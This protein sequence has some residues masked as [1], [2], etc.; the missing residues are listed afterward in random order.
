VAPQVWL[1]QAALA[2]LNLLEANRT[3][4]ARFQ[5]GVVLHWIVMVI[6]VEI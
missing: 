6:R 2:W 1:R 5:C 3:N 4:D